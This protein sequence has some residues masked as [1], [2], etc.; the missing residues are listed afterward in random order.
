MAKNIS[1]FEKKVNSPIPGKKVRED[2]LN[3][4]SIF[5]NIFPAS[6]EWPL[7]VYDHFATQD[8]RALRY[9]QLLC[10]CRMQRR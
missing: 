9:G 1:T 7:I 5:V 4:A 8:H 6:R 2:H 3:F 10:V